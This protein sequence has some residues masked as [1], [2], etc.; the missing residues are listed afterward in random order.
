MRYG[1][2]SF[3]AN[4]EPT[5][6]PDVGNFDDGGLGTL[7][8]QQY[9]YESRAGFINGYAGGGGGSNPL[10]LFGGGGIIGPQHD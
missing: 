3:N 7:P 1:F 9:V 5:K 2:V 10:Q 8:Q 4:P 6:D